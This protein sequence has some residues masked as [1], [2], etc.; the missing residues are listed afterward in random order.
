MSDNSRD[1]LPPNLPGIKVVT[2]DREQIEN[3]QFNLAPK[4]HNSELSG[5]GLATQGEFFEPPV[6]SQQ[7][8]LLGSCQ[9]IGYLGITLPGAGIRGLEDS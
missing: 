4:L 5:F 8:F 7:W 2:G 1:A 3:Y 6:D 9:E